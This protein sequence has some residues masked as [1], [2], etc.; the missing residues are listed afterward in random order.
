M[1]G[2]CDANKYEDYSRGLLGNQAYLIFVF[3]KIVGSTT[4]MLLNIGN[5]EGC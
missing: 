3:D 2:S 5:D 1:N 4:K